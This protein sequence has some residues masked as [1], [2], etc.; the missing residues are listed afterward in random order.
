MD[1]QAPDVISLVNA[2]PPTNAPRQVRIHLGTMKLKNAKDVTTRTLHNND[3]LVDQIAQFS[4]ATWLSANVEFVPR[5]ALQDT[6]LFVNICFH[7]S[8]R[9]PKDNEA[10]ISHPS[11]TPL[12]AGNDG[13]MPNVITFPL[14]FS[15][16]FISPLIRPA[17]IQ[18]PQAAISFFALTVTDEGTT[19]I[20]N[21]DPIFDVFIRGVVSTGGSAA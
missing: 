18:M 21:D 11:C 7:G 6:C 20:G 3:A 4:N 13:R 5:V 14:N 1:N 8:S 17:P 12:M 19:A 9:I 2:V 15:A 16:F 10:V